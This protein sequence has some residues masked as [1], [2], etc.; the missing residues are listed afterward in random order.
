M[1][2]C[3]VTWGYVKARCVQVEYQTQPPVA[4]FAEALLKVV[5]ISLHQ[6]QGVSAVHWFTKQ[7]QTSNYPVTIRSLREKLSTQGHQNS[8][9]PATT[10]RKQD[11]RQHKDHAGRG[12]ASI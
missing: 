3:G 8:A 4:R 11:D 2:F 10:V 12:A 6:S 7:S 9:L 1:Q 5:D